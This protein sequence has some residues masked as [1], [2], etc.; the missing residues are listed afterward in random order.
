M[1]TSLQLSSLYA[2]NCPTRQVLDLIGDKWTALIIGLLEHRPQRFSQLQRSIEGISQKML[3][4]TLRQLERDG[5]VQRTVFPEVPLRVEY[6]LTALGQT[7]CVPIAAIRD[8]ASA[9]IDD[10][11]RAQKQYDNKETSAQSSR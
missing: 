4:Q 10:I 3:S 9:N 5:L 6:R 8:W 2:A 11:T 1:E 7:L